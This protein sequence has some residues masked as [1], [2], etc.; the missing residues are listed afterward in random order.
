MLWN[1]AKYSATS[2]FRRDIHHGP[3]IGRLWQIRNREGA[4]K[5]EWF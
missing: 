1:R 2:C 4:D 3:H 5:G